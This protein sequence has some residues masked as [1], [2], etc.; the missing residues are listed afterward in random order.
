MNSS[1]IGVQCGSL[2]LGAPL[3]PLSVR[4]TVGVNYSATEIHGKEVATMVNSSSVYRE[5]L[6][7]VCIPH[8]PALLGKITSHLSNVNNC[9]DD[10]WLFF[11]R[12]ILV[13]SI[14]Y[15]NDKDLYHFYDFYGFFQSVL[16]HFEMNDLQLLSYCQDVSPLPHFLPLFNDL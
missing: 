10:P 4:G 15:L 16:C 12:R 11:R 5:T 14:Y 9:V 8:D 7:S 2:D 1:E 3:L 13:R 6:Y